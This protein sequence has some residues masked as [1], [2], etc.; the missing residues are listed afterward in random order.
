MNIT[1]APELIKKLNADAIM[2]TSEENMHYFCSFSPSEGVIIL[3]KNG[4]GIH[5][6]DSRY[7][8]AAQHYAKKSKLS[9]REIE[10]SFCDEINDY[11]AENGI[12]A[13]AFEDET[14]SYKKFNLFKEKL[15]A[16]LIPA[17][18]ALNELRSVKSEGE[19]KLMKEA[20]KIAERAYTEL[21]N[22]IKPGKTEKELAAYFDYLMAQ[23]GSGGVSFDTILLTGERTSMPHGVPSDAVI[24]KGDFV[25]MDFGATYKGYHS[26]TTRCVAVGSY[27]EEMEYYYNIV[28]SAQLAGIDALCAGAKC[29]DVYYAAHNILAEKKCA[30]YFRHSL[31]HGVGLEIHEG[32]SASPNSTDAFKPGN[33]TTIEPGIYIPGKFG[34]RIEDVFYLTEGGKENLV[35]LNKNLITV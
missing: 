30:Q 35:T 2:V 5:F 4:G 28:L 33:I 1:K 18:Q 16:D 24:K 6:V 34:I 23:N 8:E 14:I 27:S 19:I 3:T 31:G 25:L 11:T 15:N 20:Q 17:G 9:V 32:C 21:L 7:T 29:R 26:D 22:H 12:K 13:L 10:K